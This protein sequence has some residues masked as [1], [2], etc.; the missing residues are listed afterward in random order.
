MPM[1]PAIKCILRLLEPLL[2]E[3]CFSGRGTSRMRKPWGPLEEALA[4]FSD[5]RVTRACIQGVIVLKVS[6]CCCNS[7]LENERSAPESVLSGNNTAGFH[8]RNVEK[9]DVKS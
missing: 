6:Y 3:D 8:Q 7:D 1:E 9:Q 2:D 4:L 5:P